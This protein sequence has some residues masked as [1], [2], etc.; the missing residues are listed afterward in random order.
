M[1]TKQEVRCLKTLF[2]KECRVEADGLMSLLSIY[3]VYYSRRLPETIPLW[4]VCF[5]ELQTAK[6]ARAADGRYQLEVTLRSPNGLVS[7]VGSESI[8]FRKYDSRVA[9]GSHAMRL[10]DATFWEFGSYIFEV[11]VNGA[12]LAEARLMISPVPEV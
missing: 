1:G 5:L 2:C 9:Y 4:L 8:L 12:R 10:I 11:S 6:A 7:P 3:D